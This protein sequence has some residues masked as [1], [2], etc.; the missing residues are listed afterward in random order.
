MRFKAANEALAIAR[1]EADPAT[2]NVHVPADVEDVI[3]QEPAAA[4]HVL[5]PARRSKPHAPS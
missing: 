3:G 1:G 2:C 5:A 4:R